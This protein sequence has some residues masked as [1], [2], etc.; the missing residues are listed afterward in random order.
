MMRLWYALRGVFSVIWPFIKGARLTPGVR[1]ALHILLVLLII[2][3]LTYLNAQ[4]TWVEWRVGFLNH[5]WMPLLFVLIY[6][7]AF[8][9]WWLWKLLAFDQAVSYFP[10]IDAAWK[11]A[12]DALEQA[13]IRLTETPLFLIVGRPESPD[14]N[15]NLFEAAKLKLVVKPTP[16]SAR[17]PLQVCADREAVYVTCAGISALGRLAGVLALEEMGHG[18]DGESDGPEVDLTKTQIPTRKESKIVEELGDAVEGELTTLERRRLRRQIGKPLGPDFLADAQETRRLSEQVAHLCRLIVRD[19][20][21]FCPAN[22]ILVLLPLGGTDT[23]TEAQQTGE[24]CRQDMD[25]IRSVFNMDCPVFTLLCDMEVLPG[26]RE[27]MRLDAIRDPNNFLRRVG[28][29]FPLATSLSSQ[30]SLRQS[31]ASLHWL[32]NGYLQRL[33]Y[34]Y[35]GLES[36]GSDVAATTNVNSA[37]FLLLDEL[38]DRCKRLANIITQFL[39]RDEQ[40]GWMFGGCYLAATGDRNSQAYVHGLFKRLLEEQNCVTRTPRA[41]ANDARS[42]AQART[43]YMCCRWAGW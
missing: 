5:Y 17:G 29:R 7:M 13:G 31:Q 8:L 12:V 9:G 4:R 32:A 22:G 18:G 43:G 15:I 42:H 2:L 40:D 25:T 21:P 20:Q 14:R 41:L 37:L 34:K 39:A 1:W 24:A 36:A 38:H 19:R 33:V 28:Q 30:D 11:E 6:L 16:R 27:C 35:F 10:E 23:D 3:G 26:F